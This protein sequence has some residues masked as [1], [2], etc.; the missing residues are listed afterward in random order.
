M[1]VIW[2]EDQELYRLVTTRN[3]EQQY[4]LLRTLVLLGLGLKK[5]EDNQKGII[6]TGTVCD[7]HRCATLYL[8][9][10]AGEYRKDGVTLR[11]SPHEPPPYSDILR[12]M[13]EYLNYIVTNWHKQSPPRLAAYAL[14]RLNWIH[15]FDNGN[16]RTA[17]AFSYLILCL[18]YGLWLP[19][20]N[21]I[22]RQIAKNPK[23]HIKGLQLADYAYATS[24][25]ID[26]SYTEQFI[27]RL[28]AEQVQPLSKRRKR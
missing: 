10:T 26:V 28:L 22:P 5:F 15:P 9:D 24:K 1:P 23:E 17:R 8:L 11:G 13:D 4:D 3:I 7:L 6:N 21:I 25:T 18:K 14:W 12:Y 2:E 27:R 20:K 16:G 19:G